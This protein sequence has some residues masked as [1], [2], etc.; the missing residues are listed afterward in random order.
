M[1]TVLA[2]IGVGLATACTGSMPRQGRVDFADATGE[3]I[4]AGPDASA[5]SVAASAAGFESSPVV[6]L[7]GEASIT[8]FSDDSMQ[9]FLPLLVAGEGGVAAE[10]ERLGAETVVVPQESDLSEFT[11]DLEVVE[12]DPEASLEDIEAALPSLTYD[13]ERPSV[14][15]LVDPSADPS[16]AALAVEANV[17]AAGGRTLQVPGGDPRATAPIVDQLTA[18]Q[19]DTT[20]IAAGETFGSQEQLAGRLEMALTAPQLPGGGVALFPGRRV[21]AMYGTPGVPGLG[22]LGEQGLEASI[23]RVKE[24]A[25]GYDE[26]SEVP[27][28]PGFEI[29][30]TVATSGA[31]PDGDYSNELDIET[32]RPWV[33]A[34]G[35]A[36]VYVTLDLQPG[37]AD[38][39][40]QAKRYEDLLAQPHVG[41]ALD[42]EWRLEPGQVPLAQIG[43]VDAAE[44]NETADWLAALT[45][46]HHLPQK[47]LVLHQFRLHMIDDREQIDTSHEELAIILHADGHGIPKHKMETWSAIQQDLPD[48]VWM[49]WKNFYDEDTPM[50]TPEETFALEPRPWF[51]SYQ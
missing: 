25:E 42:P 22:V 28:V 48:G 21:V 2:V 36:G 31:G 50:F 32:L 49:A 41:L 6:F 23:E 24:L 26:F 34:A 4:A 44:I 5:A 38:F 20:F 43:S 46:E 9:S 35:E 45:R 16:A 33:E 14:T 19:K 11:G 27:V 37:R 30:T 18:E 15:A 17:R 47:A 29:I 1:T 7:T 40:S 3:V 12:V 39:L 51:V 10:I 13:E 8:N